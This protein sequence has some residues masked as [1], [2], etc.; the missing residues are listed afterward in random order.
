MRGSWQCYRRLEWICCLETHPTHHVLR[1]WRR[2]QRV[3]LKCQA[4]STSIVNHSESIKSINYMTM[5]G[6]S[7]VTTSWRVLRLRLEETPSSFGGKLRIYWIRSRG[8]PTRGGPPAWEMGVG[9]TTPHRRKIS[10][11]QKTTRSLGPGRIPWIN[12][13]RERKW[14]WDL[15]PGML[16]VCIGQVH[17]G[18]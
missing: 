16:E 8:Q 17:S 15:A 2:R 9:L 5:L 13:P 1:P 10:L 14:I 12:D 7:L 11:L 18:Q 3:S 4:E 6:G